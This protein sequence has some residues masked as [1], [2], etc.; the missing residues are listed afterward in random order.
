MDPRQIWREGE[1]QVKQQLVRSA[2]PQLAE[3]LDNGAG[4]KLGKD[5]EPDPQ[6]LCEGCGESTGRLAIGR[7]GDSPV[8]AYCCARKPYA[9]RKLSRVTG[10]A[11]GHAEGW[12]YGGRRPTP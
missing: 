7:A 1:G 9:G 6:P 11:P 10:W 3:A 12:G 2:W 5:A 8:C 4:Y